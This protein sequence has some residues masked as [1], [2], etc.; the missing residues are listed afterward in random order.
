VLAQCNERADVL[1]GDSWLSES[2]HAKCRR[3]LVVVALIIACLSGARLSELQQLAREFLTK[4]GPQSPSCETRCSLL[5]CRDRNGHRL[6]S[7]KPV[8]TRAPQKLGPP[9]HASARMATNVRKCSVRDARIGPS[10]RSSTA[11]TNEAEALQGNEYAACAD[12][13]CNS[14]SGRV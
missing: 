14:F 7:A 5:S 11:E 6:H 12:A 2:S 3:Y 1:S 8:I 4:T 13:K 9:K 10:T